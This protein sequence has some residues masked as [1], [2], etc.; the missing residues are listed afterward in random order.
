M[1]EKNV[2]LSII[3]SQIDTEGEET[4]MEFFTEGELVALDDGGWRLEYTESE[5]SGME[6]TVTSLTLKDGSV[7]LDR[8]GTHGAMMLFEEGIR[9]TL[10][11]MT[12]M[13]V[14]EMGIHPSH[15]SYQVEGGQ[16]GLHLEYEL[17][18]QG[19]RAGANTM[20]LNFR[21]RANNGSAS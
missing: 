10:L 6:G 9:S 20:K 1:S 14:L 21:P 16:G 19:Q 8:S 5:I 4:K 3:S 2:V 18:I 15:V 13:G 7:K 12:P 11:Y 17:D